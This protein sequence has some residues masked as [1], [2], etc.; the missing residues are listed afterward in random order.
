M[1]LKK[2][3]KR[4]LIVLSVVVIV[5]LFDQLVLSSGGKENSTTNKT[6]KDAGTQ[7]AKTVTTLGKDTKTNPIAEKPSSE[8]KQFD[9]WGRDPFYSTRSSSIAQKLSGSKKKKVKAPELQG[10]FWKQGKT[11]VL[12]DNVILTEGEE[13]EGI[14]VNRIRD[15]EVL[16]S[17]GGQSFTLFWRESP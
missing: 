12:V 15:K 9:S 7:L 3:E 4:L 6:L 16:C 1:T 17:K 10:F 8:T 11:F 14:R 13:K 2:N 5:F